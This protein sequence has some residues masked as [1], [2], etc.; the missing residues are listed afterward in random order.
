ME[1]WKSSK[2][3]THTHFW[4][5]YTCCIN[6]AHQNWRSCV[7]FYSL[8]RVYS[9]S[10]NSQWIKWRNNK[11]NPTVMHNWTIG[12]FLGFV[13]T[14]MN[15]HTQI[16]PTD[17]QTVVPTGWPQATGGLER[18]WLFLIR[19]T[20]HIFPLSSAGVETTSHSKTVIPSSDW[21]VDL[22]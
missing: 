11:F 9:Q 21:W 7:S 2:R 14:V 16:R 10:Y 22:H 12:S 5:K 6:P 15:F 13:V 18:I 8:R 19:N 20:I 17:Q 1:R 4:Y 3:H